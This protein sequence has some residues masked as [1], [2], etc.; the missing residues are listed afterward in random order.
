MALDISVYLYVSPSFI[1]IL[2]Y[3]TG[4]CLVQLDKNVEWTYQK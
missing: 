4:T 2:Y 1:S 3:N